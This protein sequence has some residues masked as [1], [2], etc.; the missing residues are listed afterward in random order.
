VLGPDRG[1]PG[2][3]PGRRPQRVPEAGGDKACATSFGIEEICSCC[4]KGGWNETEICV[5]L[6]RNMYCRIAG[7]TLDIEDAR[8]RS[9]AGTKLGPLSCQTAAFRATE[10]VS[11]GMLLSPG[12]AAPL[13]RNCLH[14]GGMIH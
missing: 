6:L 4:K 2:H 10:P 14:I 11:H 5:M 12:A 8:G 9:E 7:I 1:L 13:V 3:D